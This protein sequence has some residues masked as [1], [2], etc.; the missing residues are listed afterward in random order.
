VSRVISGSVFNGRIHIS[1]STPIHLPPQ[2]DGDLAAVAKSIQQ[3]SERS[4][5][6]SLDE[7]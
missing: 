7:G 5:R 4:K 6:A 2:F 3:V 1:A